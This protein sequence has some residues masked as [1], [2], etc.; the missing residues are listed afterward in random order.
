[1]KTTRVNGNH[2][3]YPRATTCLIVPPSKRSVVGTL[4]LIQLRTAASIRQKETLSTLNQRG[5]PHC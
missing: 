3:E 5:L 4:Y 1:M 2:S